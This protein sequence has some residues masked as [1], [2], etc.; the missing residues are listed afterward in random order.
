MLWRCGPTFSNSSKWD[1]MVGLPAEPSSNEPGPGDRLGS[2]VWGESASLSLSSVGFL[3]TGVGLTVESR[4]SYDLLSI[5]ATTSSPGSWDPSPVTDAGA[6]SLKDS[7]ACLRL[8]DSAP[9][10]R[11]KDVAI[12]GRSFARPDTVC[13]SHE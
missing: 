12:I 6:D 13:G 1:T 10:I 11:A 5:A 2:M 3:G 9:V 8:G 4:T 7:T